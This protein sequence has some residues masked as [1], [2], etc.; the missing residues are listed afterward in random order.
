MGLFELKDKVAVVTGGAGRLGRRFARVLRRHGAK[1]AV[2]DLA[3]GDLVGDGSAGAPGTDDVAFFEVDVAERR[4]V[5]NA[6]RSLSSLWGAPHVL[7][8]NAGLDS[9]PDSEGPPFELYEESAWERVLDVNLKGTFLCSQLVGARMAEAGR[10]T[11]INI[12]SIYGL[13]SPDQRI[14]P[15]RADGTPF[16]KPAAYG[17]SKAGVVSLARYLAAYWGKS[18]LRVNTLTLGGVY[19]EQDPD[20]V[21][22]YSER[23]PLGRMAREDEFDGAILF[24]A[25]DASSYMTGANLVID[26]GWTA[27]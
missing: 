8:N 25:S 4:S 13:G 5:E 6:V 11:I 16:Y 18:G 7:I 3:P 10:G 22:A 12:S 14:Y 1:V 17:A 19:N 20:F 2:F 26:G 9:P 15:P 27:W 21:A 24:L 23:V